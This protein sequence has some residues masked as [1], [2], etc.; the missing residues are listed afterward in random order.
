MPHSCGTIIWSLCHSG[1]TITILLCHTG[2]S[3]PNPHC[4]AQSL[5]P[6]KYVYMI[7]L[8]C[9]WLNKL[10]VYL[11]KEYAV[12]ISHSQCQNTLYSDEEDKDLFQV[13]DFIFFT[14]LMPIFFPLWFHELCNFLFYKLF[15]LILVTISNKCSFVGVFYVLV[16]FLLSI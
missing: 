14:V 13:I 6:V 15:Y 4:G 2:D 5:P 1:G 9:Y 12:R 3:I 11:C 7:F 10:T 8:F 16:I